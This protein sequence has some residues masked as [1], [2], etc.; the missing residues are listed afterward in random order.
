MPS[1]QHPLIRKLKPFL[2]NNAMD[3]SSSQKIKLGIFVILGTALLLGAVYILGSR[4]SLLGGSFQL[5]A[6]F[7]N[8][9]GL[10]SGNNVRFSGIDVGTVTDIHMINDTT[11]RVDMLVENEMLQHIHKNAIAGVGTDGLVGSMIINITPGSGQAPLVEPGDELR[12]YSRIASEDMLNTLSVTNENAALLTAD[13]L[14]VTQSVLQGKGTVS[15]LLNDTAMAR[16]VYL[17]IHNLKGLS[18]EVNLAMGEVRVLLEQVKFKGSP[19]EVLLSDTAAG[20]QVKNLLVR[21]DSSGSEFQQTVQNLNALVKDI[22]EGEGA[23]HYLATDT[24]LVQNLDSSMKNIEQAT[25]RF[26]ENMEA[27]KHNILFRRYFRR[28][29]KKAEK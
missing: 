26:N 14:K 18:E 19:A 16:D 21:L 28:Q 20:N 9:N 3:K 1:F 2:K 22:K 7:K 25:A 17:A 6:V 13:L 24:S 23:I 29:E 10:Q 27:L 5:S 4:E 8:T 11:I 12:T 15:K